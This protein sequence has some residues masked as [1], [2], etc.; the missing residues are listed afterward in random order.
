M[1]KIN[2]RWRTLYQLDGSF[3]KCQKEILTA[4]GQTFFEFA[5]LF[6]RVHAQG[7][8]LRNF[9]R[10]YSLNIGTRFSSLQSRYWSDQEKRARTSNRSMIYLSDYY[11]KKCSISIRCLCN[12]VDVILLVRQTMKKNG[13][14]SR[15]V[16]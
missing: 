6:S 9:A 10:W 5:F 8:I 15:I 14:C 11:T 4:F 3:F 12:Y 2:I 16:K 1:K 13:I 7:K